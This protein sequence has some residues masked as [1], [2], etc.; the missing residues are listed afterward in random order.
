MITFKGKWIAF[1]CMVLFLG[2]CNG[3]EQGITEISLDISNETIM[4]VA[5]KGL[6]HWLSVIP[7]GSELDYGFSSRAEFAYAK[8]G[9]PVRMYGFKLETRPEYSPILALNN[10][11]VPVEVDGSYRTFLYVRATEDEVD[12]VGIGAAALARE[13]GEIRQ[14][15]SSA[16]G[17]LRV[18]TLGADFIIDSSELRIDPNPDIFVF[19]LRSAQESLRVPASPLHIKI[20]IEEIGERNDAS[21]PHG[22]NFRN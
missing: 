3:E 9:E 6:N 13:I 16:K 8:I 19:P 11:N 15:G 2:A 10:W 18:Y 20:V 22:C 1:F 4:Q 21:P 17:L 7:A 14:R 5:L 12:V